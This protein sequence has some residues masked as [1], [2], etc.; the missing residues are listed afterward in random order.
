MNKIYACS[1][2]H[3]MYKLWEKIREYLDET[4]TLIFLGDAIDRG[5]DGI[6]IVK[7]LLF[8]KRVIYLM[9]NHEE[10]LRDCFSELFHGDYGGVLPLW[11][12]NGGEPTAAALLKESPETVNYI[13]QRISKLP[14]HYEYVNK[15]GEKIFLCH[16]GTQPGITEE[17]W[18][19]G[20]LFPKITDAYTWNRDHIYL[21]W[22]EKTGVDFIVHGHTPVQFLRQKLLIH[23]V[24]DPCIVKYCQGHK[25]DIDLCSVAT[26]RAALLDLD[27]LEPIYFDAKEDSDGFDYG[28]LY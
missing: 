10:F 13:R 14:R 1:D 24:N 3:G 20:I 9:G 27:T 28:I 2:L 19:E 8:D 21:D 4:D 7:E 16:A 17:Q 5:E 18:E 25:I 15:K 12:G 22:V 11:V 23:G 6:K 26:Q